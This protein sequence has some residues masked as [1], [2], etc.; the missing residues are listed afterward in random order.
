MPRARDAAL[1][2]AFQSIV[3]CQIAVY[4]ALRNYAQLLELRDA[5]EALD[6]TLEEERHADG[7]LAGI[8]EC[9]NHAALQ[10]G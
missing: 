6:P 8:S 9:I 7:L 10:L 3:L 1:R 5:A 4:G 2:S